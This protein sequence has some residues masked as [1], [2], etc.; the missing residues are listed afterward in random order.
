MRVARLV[1]SAAAQESGSA[2][3]ELA[4]T[5]S[6]IGLP[7]LFGTIY[8]GVLV[9]DNIE[10]ANAAH[11][12]AM[13]GMQSSTYASDTSGMTS[14]AQAEAPD[15][16]TGLVVTPTAF[17]ACSAAIDGTQYTTQSDATAGCSGGSN[18]ALEFVKVTASYVATPF[19][20]IPGMQRSV[21]VSG[22][23]VMEVEE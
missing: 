20:S 17:Y 16:A 14:A 18:H 13:Y 9:F 19:A 21:T 22:V 5:L 6:L 2:L 8:S 4:L 3:I 23:S 7:L 1:R 10:I 12:G 11:A 15:L